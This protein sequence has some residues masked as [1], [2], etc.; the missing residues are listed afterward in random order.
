[1]KSIL[2]TLIALLAL[3]FTGCSTPQIE[4]SA[5]YVAAEA[6]T[7]AILQKNP[8]A[9]PTVQ[10]LVSDWGKFQGGTL[11]SANEATLL[12]SIVAA[13]GKSLTPT[14]AA[15]LDGA[16]Q[17]VLANQNASAPTPIG[18]AAAAIITDVIN[19]AARAVV[20]YTTPAPAS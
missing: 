6:A 11:T 7:A 8:A 12:Q 9:L 18:G 5:A 13:T 19:G 10:L 1:M 15:V 3:A 14:E 2:L 17:Q 4:A 16:T 20:V